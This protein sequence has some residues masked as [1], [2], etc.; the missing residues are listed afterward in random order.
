MGRCTGHLETEWEG[1]LP[2]RVRL[3][4]PL[5]DSPGG[6][7]HLIGTPGER[8]LPSIMA[9]LWGPGGPPGGAGGLKVADPLLAVTPQGVSCWQAVLAVHP[10]TSAR[11][12]QVKPGGV[13]GGRGVTR[14]HNMHSIGG[15]AGGAAGTTLEAYRWGPAS[16]QPPNLEENSAGA[17]APGGPNNCK[18]PTDQQ[19]WARQCAVGTA[20]SGRL[21]WTHAQLGGSWGFEIHLCIQEALNM[22]FLFPDMAQRNRAPIVGHGGGLCVWRGLFPRGPHGAHTL[23][24]GLTDG[25]SGQGDARTE[26]WLR[27]GSGV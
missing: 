15:R 1:F 5:G 16:L 2:A 26:A 13:L 3:S 9:P 24:W 23:A 14:S 4:S 6:D 25:L 17:P 21:S 20:L 11:S 10:G 18:R 22:A 7:T 12:W 8:G 27:G 19:E